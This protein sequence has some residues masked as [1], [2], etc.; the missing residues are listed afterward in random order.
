MNNISSSKL[1]SKIFKWSS[2]VLLLTTLSL[3]AWLQTD[4]SRGTLAA[5]SDSGMAL[6]K[7]GVTTSFILIVAC[8][9]LLLLG[10]FIRRPIFRWTARLLYCAMV[11]FS[12]GAGRVVA[13][14]GMRGYL[15]VSVGWFMFPTR[16]ID[17]S[18]K[19]VEPDVRSTQWSVEPQGHSQVI[20]KAGEI[21]H[22]IWTGPLIQHSSIEM[23]RWSY[24]DKIKP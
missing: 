15:T 2:T 12:L 4:V 8:T 11:V 6:V 22:A 5:G 20:L 3:H 14:G 1:I 16:I 21:S 23:L 19:G 24:S 18:A 7:V 9:V 17:L 13:R 10:T